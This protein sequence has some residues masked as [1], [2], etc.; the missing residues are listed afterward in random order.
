MKWVFE[1]STNYMVTFTFVP[2]VY[3]S[4]KLSTGMQ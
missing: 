4:E 1:N 2:I 3:I